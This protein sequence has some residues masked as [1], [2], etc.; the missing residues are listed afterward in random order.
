[1]LD[2]PAMSRDPCLMRAPS[3]VCA[4]AGVALLGGACAGC[5]NGCPDWPAPTLDVPTFC[6]REGS[7]QLS[8]GATLV[9]APFACFHLDA[10]ASV[11]VPVAGLPGSPFLV[12]LFLEG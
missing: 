3:L 1:S 2:R 11:T 5:S 10:A 7:C 6:E 4:V 12:I 9:D 8:P